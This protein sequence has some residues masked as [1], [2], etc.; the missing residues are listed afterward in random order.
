MKG[1]SARNIRA[2][3]LG[4]WG[5]ATALQSAGDIS[6][7]GTAST[8]TSFD[9]TWTSRKRTVNSSSVSGLYDV[10]INAAGGNLDL[11]AT[12]IYAYSGNAS[13][14]AS[15]NV[16][17]GA[18]QNWAAHTATS[19][20]STCNGRLF[21]WCYSR[22][23]WTDHYLRE[24]LTAVPATVYA[25]SLQVT[26]G[27]NLDTYATKLASWGGRTDLMAGA[28]ANYYAVYNQTNF[29]DT[30]NTS[31][32]FLGIRYSRDTGISSSLT[33]APIVT[34]LQS[35]ATLTGSSGADTLLQGTRV[36]AAGGSTF[37]A[38]AGE[39]ARTDARI[40]L[41]GVKTTVQ[42]VKTRESNYVLWQ[43]QSGSGGT[44]ETFALP[45]FVGGTTFNAP[46]GLVVQIADGSPLKA[47]IQTLASQPGMGYL[48]D[49][50]ARRDVNWQPVKLAFDQW[51][52]QQQ[53]LT[54]A[55]AALVAV[56]VAWATGGM[57]AELLGTTGTTTSLMANA[58]FTSLAAQASITLIN[59]QGNLGKTL[60]DL[61]SSN[62][63]KAALTAALTAG[64][65]DGINAL[66]EI[67]T[68]RNKLSLTDASLVDKFTYNLVN[69]TGRA[70][71]DAA[72]NGGS[73]ESA[74][75]AALV[76]G[77]VDTVQGAAS[78]QIKALENDYVI[79]KLAH[80]LAGC[81]AGA[82]AGGACQDGA[83]GAAV[84]EMVAGLFTKPGI[85][86]TPAE[87]AAFDNKVLS[88]SK[89][90]AG[91]ISAY[92]GGNA[93]TA[94]TTAETAVRNNYLTETQKQ[95]RDRALAACKTSACAVSVLLKYDG[96]DAMQDVGLAVGVMAGMGY[97]TA[98]QIGALVDLAK[99]IPETLRVLTAIVNDAEFRAK[100]GD[101]IA[102]DYLQRINMQ[103][104]AYNEG[105]WGGSV[106]A[107]VEAGRLAV[108]VVGACTAAV[109]AG[110]V[111]AVTA[112]SGAKVVTEALAQSSQMTTQFIAAMA[113]K[114]VQIGAI[115]SFKSADEVNSL[116]NAYSYAPAWKVGSTVIETTLTPGTRVQMVVSESDF[117]ALTDPTGKANISRSFGGWA[118]FDSVPNQAY[119]RNQLAITPAFKPNV[120][121]VIEIEITKPIQ[122]QVGLV[123]S[124]GGAAVGGGNQL[125]FLIPP[126]DRS[127]TFKYVSGSGRALP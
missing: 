120:G 29:K 48:N 111:V 45:S 92:T 17:L 9:G 126:I 41:E 57:G 71:T 90:A 79:H 104:S 7:T 110:K 87:L 99:N 96:T 91:G 75:N 97:Q 93:Q 72:I 31:S 52:Y 2:Q 30:R 6:I 44:T 32:S 11:D 38:G 36:N 80:A 82:A 35:Q 112:K 42:T 65:L 24:Y 86:A 60:R 124:Q 19:Q 39:T 88:V 117:L 114:G 100:V 28:A 50:A 26:A 22:T 102:D 55:G 20:G 77:V 14:T 107:G 59:N 108:D 46:G 67:Q 12:N 103:S 4:A 10:K 118:T 106:T 105:G 94:I 85:N 40:I 116:M 37:K 115:Q 83:I 73:L 63:A 13:L 54:P 109:G 113:R 98:E 121:Y 84:G 49:L 18:A 16:N 15:G 43:K 27:N 25:R 69:A 66:P 21:G 81:V 51:S 76:G 53:G 56:A 58:A 123:G 23:N 34:S 127:N 8:T 68:L 64:V 33:N 3:G 1:A 61:A 101:L 89:L 5:A 47:Q 70:L 78:S 95:Q 122:A 119:A 62:T 74:L 125:N